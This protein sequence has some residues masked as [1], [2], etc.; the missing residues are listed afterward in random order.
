MTIE[1]IHN[2]INGE[3]CEAADRSWIENINPATGEVVNLLP[4]SN[5]EDAF[6]AVAAAHDCYLAG[7]QGNAGAGGL[8]AAQ[9]CDLLMA[10]AD[11][12]TERVEEIAAAE[13]HDSGKPYLNALKGDVPRSIDN[14]RFFAKA[15]VAQTTPAV[16]AGNSI[17]YVLRQPLGAVSLITPWNFPL[18]LLMRKKSVV[19][20]RLGPC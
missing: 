7:G 10:V 13:S 20:G 9:R 8:N 11:A 5:E 6:D 14:L 1:H 15:A 12:M 3:A 16:S 19:H 17:N 4:R 18:H 2:W